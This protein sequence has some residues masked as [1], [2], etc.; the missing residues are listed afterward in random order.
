MLVEPTLTAT[1]NFIGNWKFSRLQLPCSSNLEECYACRP[2]C[3]APHL[4]LSDRRSLYDALGPYYTVIRIDPAVDVSGMITAAGRRGVPLF[5]L[6][7]DAPEA[8][9]LYARK[10]TLVR[11]DQHVAWRGDETPN[12]PLE[13]ID[14]LRG[15]AG[16]HMVT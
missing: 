10:L 11:P 14:L 8:K 2:G 13:L 4:W 16:A 7:V 15:A 3:R 1:P 12:S 9:S 6:D 5:V